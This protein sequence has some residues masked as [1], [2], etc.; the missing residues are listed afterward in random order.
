MV[1]GNKGNGTPR[2]VVSQ[3][4]DLGSRW[5]AGSAT[6]RG[7]PDKEDAPAQVSQDTSSDSHV[8]ALVTHARARDSPESMFREG[9]LPPLYLHLGGDLWP[10]LQQ[11]LFVGKIGHIPIQYDRRLPEIVSALQEF[12]HTS[13][14]ALM[15]GT[16]V[17]EFYGAEEISMLYRIV[18]VSAENI[19]DHP[20]QP[21]PTL[22]QYGFGF[23]DTDADVVYHLT[24]YL[25]Q[26]V[27]LVPSDPTSQRRR[28]TT[29]VYPPREIQDL[30]LD[31]C[32]TKVSLNQMGYETYPGHAVL[33]QLNLASPTT[34]CRPTGEGSRPDS[35]MVSIHTSESGDSEEAFKQVQ[36]HA[37]SLRPNWEEPPRGRYPTL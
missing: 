5:M 22:H 12:M 24:G 1:A 35:A 2:G 6:R 19:G 20:P 27:K 18:L 8:L 13:V 33:K 3:I 11:Y 36:D 14:V 7:T 15:K 32:G 21:P 26:C 17:E 4:F 23:K 25:D 31:L 30:I 16:G 9:L 37:A 29:Y 10:D 28:L 34:I